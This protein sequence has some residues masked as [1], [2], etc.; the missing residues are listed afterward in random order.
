[1]KKLLY[2][3]SS[4]T[5]SQIRDRSL[6]QVLASR[7][8]DG[9]FDQI[10]SAHPVDSHPSLTQDIAPSGKPIEE[11][12]SPSHVFVRGRYGRYTWLVRVAPL[13][14]LIG[15]I[16]FVSTLV[17]IV[18]R[19]QISV[20]RVGDPLFCG[21]IGLIVSKLTGAKLVVR[22]N[23]DHDLGRANS[24]API[25]PKLFRSGKVEDKV[26]RLVLKR[27]DLVFVPSPPCGEFAER[28]GTKP[29]LIVT[30]R[31]GNIIDP[32]HLIPQADRDPLDDPEMEARL[33]E[34]PWMVHIG[35]M[36]KIKIAEDCYK[37]LKELAAQDDDVGLLMIGDGPMRD[38]FLNWAAA[39]GLSDRVWL[40]GNIDQGT[41]ARV[42][43]YCTL[44]LSPATGRSLAEAAF[45]ALPIV[46]YDLEWQPEMIQTD[47]TGILVPV[48]DATEMA[49]GA[50]RFLAD[51][52]LRKRLG[53][54][55]RERAFDLLDPTKQIQRE[56]DAY[57][58]LEALS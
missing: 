32:R 29:D 44:V 43:P 10:W 36:S 14:V 37:V 40:M 26:E 12:L 25:N 11:R 5:L 47:V 55:A 4:Y 3:D 24:G 27:A 28:K 8:L 42:L 23:G 7:F 13:N 18:R 34:R 31:N 16:S 1:M 33:K 54:G 56:I 50:E 45:A 51:P 30:I 35:R 6:D 22:V 49:Q 38:D 53:E 9:Y 58:S 21:L 20:I 52:K 17:G 39:D 2:I 15:L 48:R 57:A 46:A 41:L 19:E